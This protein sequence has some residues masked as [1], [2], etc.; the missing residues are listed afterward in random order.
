MQ[1]YRPPASLRPVRGFPARRLLRKLR[2]RCRPS[3]AVAASPGPSWAGAPSSRVPVSNLGAGR[4]RALPLATQAAGVENASRRGRVHRAQQQAT[5]MLAAPDRSSSMPSHLTEAV[6]L[7]VR[8]V[9]R[10]LR[11]LT[12]GAAVA[13]PACGRWSAPGTVQAD[14]LM[15]PDRRRPVR[16][17]GPLPPDVLLGQGDIAAAG[18][19][20]ASV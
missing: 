2:P 17:L 12:M 20:P 16:L 9:L 10:T 13:H 11:C 8:G 6:W 5:Q 19:K 7:K 4:W 18:R 3:P 1:V 15:T 14:L